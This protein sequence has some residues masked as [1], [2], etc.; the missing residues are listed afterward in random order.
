MEVAFAEALR[1]LREVDGR[2]FEDRGGFL[3]ADRVAGDAVEAAVGADE[4]LAVGD[5]LGVRG[6]FVGFL[7]GQAVL[8]VQSES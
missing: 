6:R 2:G 4:L 5:L 8:M 1:G 3:F 7:L